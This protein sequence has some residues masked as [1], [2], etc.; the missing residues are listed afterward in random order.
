MVCTRDLDQS[1]PVPGGDQPCQERPGDCRRHHG[2]GGAVDEQDGDGCGTSPVAL[3]QRERIGGSPGAGALRSVSAEEVCHVQES[4]RHVGLGDLVEL[5]VLDHDGIWSER[6]CRRAACSGRRREGRGGETDD[7]CRPAAGRV[8]EECHPARICSIPGTDVARNSDRTGDI[9]EGGRISAT[10]L[11][12]LS[13]ACHHHDRALTGRNRRERV[14][15]AAI[16]L[17]RGARA[18]RQDHDQWPWPSGRRS[19]DVHPQTA[20]L[21]GIRTAGDHRRV[22]DVVPLSHHDTAA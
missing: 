7:G 22:C 8:A 2:V 3:R 12:A 11:G 13:P 6:S 21:A 20:P 5:A 9:L 17:I 1:T 15:N 14:E 19:G 4:I 16:P 18:A 10:P